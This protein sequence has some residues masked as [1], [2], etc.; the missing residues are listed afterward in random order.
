MPMISRFVPRCLVV[1]TLPVLLGP[2]LAWAQ[3]A[4]TDADLVRRAESEGSLIAMAQFCNIPR[5][6]IREIVGKLEQSTLKAAAEAKLTLDSDAYR[7]YAVAGIRGTSR[8][9]AM[10]PSSGPNYDSNCDEVRSKIAAAMQ[11]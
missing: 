4:L 5:E 1:L 7:Q 2:V 8:L 3:E 6:Q 9:L 11:K 10:V